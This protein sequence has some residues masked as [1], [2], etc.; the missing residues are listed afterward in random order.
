[1]Q[2]PNL[3][4]DVPQLGLACSS[5]WQFWLAV[6]DRYLGCT[7]PDCALCK[8]NPHKTCNPADLFDEAYADNQVLKARCEA[9]LYVELVNATTGEV[10]PAPGVE[11][12]V[13]SCDSLGCWDS[14]SLHPAQSHAENLL[15]HEA[16]L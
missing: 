7:D 9:E 8:N 5:P 3:L 14:L 1:M 16:V 4:A 13:L 11:V 12:Q 2:Q 6:P 15:N 10:Y